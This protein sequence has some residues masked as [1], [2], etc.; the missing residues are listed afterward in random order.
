MVYLNLIADV[1]DQGVADGV[2][3]HPLAVPE[4]LQA[5]DAVLEE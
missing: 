3:G 5:G 4:D 1:D 2:D